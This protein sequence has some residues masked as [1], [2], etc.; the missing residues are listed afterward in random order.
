MDI[1]VQSRGSNILS[2]A[3]HE[4]ES[5]SMISWNDFDRFV[6]ALAGGTSTLYHGLG[7]SKVFFTLA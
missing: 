3:E 4:N 2:K 6:F 5:M 7:I 1:Q